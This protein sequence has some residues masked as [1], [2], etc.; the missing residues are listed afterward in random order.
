M[1]L[2][3]IIHD[4]GLI[5]VFSA[6]I[7]FIFHKLKW[8]VILGYLLS[9]LLLGPHSFYESPIHN[10]A[11][12]LQLSEL[13]VLF[14][15]FYIGLEFDLKKLRE[16]IGSSFLAIIF[17]TVGMIV[18]G[19]VA[20][21]LLGWS[22][23]DGIFLGSILAIS[24]TMVTISILG[25][26][27]ALKHAYGQLTLGIL[28]LEDIVAIILLVILAGVGVTGKIEISSVWHVIFLI[29]VFV[30][31]VY[32]VGK[33]LAPRL[34]RMLGEF[35]SAEMVTL[36]SVAFAM[37]LGLLAD[38]FKFSLALGAFLAGAILS[39]SILSEEIEHAVEPFKNLFSSVFFVTV[40]MLIDPFLILKYWKQ[41]LFVS[42]LTVLGK[43]IT[44][45]AGLFLVGQNRRNAF[46]ASITKAQ[47]GEF[48]FVIA[49]L[50]NT[51]G[52]AHEGLTAI[53]VGVALVTILMSPILNY[54]SSVIFE[55]ISK[56]M[57]RTIVR[58]ANIY[59]AFLQAVKEHLYNSKILNFIRRPIIH[60][61]A[62]FALFN[63]IVLTASWGTVFWL[64]SSLLPNYKMQGALLIWITT[65]IICLPFLIAVIRNFD[66]MIL[67]ISEATFS[68]NKDKHSLGERLKSVFHALLLCLVT[69]LFSGI[70]LSAAS[71]YFPSGFAIIVF[72]LV[73]VGVSL[74]AWNSLI[75]INSRLEAMFLESIEKQMK[76][77]EG[78]RMRGLALHQ[79]KEKYPWPIS[80]HEII[81]KPSTVAC[82]QKIQDLNLRGMTGASIIG[83]NRHGFT[84]YDPDPSTR[85]FPED[86]LFILGEEPQLEAAKTFLSS[87]VELLHGEQH[88][89]P[90]FGLHQV[91]V[92]KDS[93]FVGETLA[94]SNIRRKYGV[95]IVGIQRE[96]QRI[97][98]PAPEQMIQLGDILILVGSE[99]A[100]R[101]F[102]KCQLTRKPS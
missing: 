16:L 39:Q 90:S 64:E 94:S 54:N 6:I 28:I 59:T 43:V 46:C 69:V 53:T 48:S 5:V 34:L 57:P 50:A 87:K 10:D 30:T 25:Q 31:M 95:N 97:T 33:L 92:G 1:E 19:I 70:Y 3:P 77:D 61:V 65:A 56:G 67:I 35:D 32:V 79:I 38:E 18:L 71:E 83:I 21:P 100:V 91:F 68:V 17:Q 41:I 88:E 58:L 13:G 24:S 7:S 73:I 66:A 98:S 99:K 40:G 11:S 37:G 78:S 96:H 63:G 74:F 60:I 42:I 12:I 36:F 62:Y 14:L 81:I 102:E 76:H 29:G 72:V 93:P 84:E 45:F 101:E 55:K 52:I 22:K 15:M 9:G 23:V 8:P 2:P 20:A 49:S 82:G 89:I 85:M 4:L 44:V 86:H 75:K 80:L 47:I 51:L 26:Q 27:G